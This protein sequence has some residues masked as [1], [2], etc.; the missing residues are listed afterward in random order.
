MLP[1]LLVALYLAVRAYWQGGRKL[2]GIPGETWTAIWLAAGMCAAGLLGLAVHMKIL[3]LFSNY[4]LLNQLS[5][6]LASPQQIQYIAESYLNLFGYQKERALLTFG[7]MANIAGILAAA[8]MIILSFSV[9]FRKQEGLFRRAGLLM[10]PA[11]MLITL[12]IFLLTTGAE[13]YPQYFISAFIWLF[14]LLGLLISETKLSWRRPT[15]RQA[16]AGL[17]VLCLAVSGVFYNRYFITPGGQ[18]GRLR[19]ILVCEIRLPQAAGGRGNVS[20]G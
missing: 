14:P 5:L 20:G 4:Q 16:L 13:N 10:Y 8:A 6:Q 1:I 19:R 2:S 3:P 11:A 12:M 18:T 7:G 9:F 15:F 17:M